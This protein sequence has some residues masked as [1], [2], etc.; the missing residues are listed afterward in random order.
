MSDTYCGKK[1]EECTS[2]EKLN[3]PGCSIG[4]G[5]PRSGDCWLASCCRE[6]KHENCETCTSNGYCVTLKNRYSMPE[7]RLEKQQTQ[8]ILAEEKAKKAAFLGKWFWLLF[9]LVIP[10]LIGSIFTQENIAAIFPAMKIP[11]EI[12]NVTCAVVYSLILVK[13][14]S[15]NRNYRIAG[16]CG[17]AA[18]AITTAAEGINNSG[19]K[20]IVLLPGVVLA[21]V[22]TYHEYT[23][24]GDVTA[25]FDA[26]LSAKWYDLWKWFFRTE[27][28]MFG[29]IV[30]MLLI[31]ILGLVIFLASMIG[32]V[33]VEILK[34]VY[35]YRMLKLFRE[36]NAN[37][38]HCDNRI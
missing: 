35:L 8:Q 38:N 5:N 21:M 2:R 26:E 6:K 1:C 9:W 30:V 27:I 16:F 33:V 13:V 15:E 29:S 28:G 4:P 11:G 37:G 22:R 18:L 10:S 34:L 25:E 19:L 12:L 32:N 7:Y 36:E 24:H 17:L 14:S 3:C 23:S 20:L 31:P